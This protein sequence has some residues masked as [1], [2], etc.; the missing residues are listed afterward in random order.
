MKMHKLLKAFVKDK[1]GKVVIWQ[2]P[3]FPIVAWAVFTLAG[4]IAQG[5]LHDIFLACGSISLLI[6]ACLEIISGASYFR[7]TLG[8]VVLVATV[9]SSYSSWLA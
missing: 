6:W 5:P 8:L 4:R 3:N 7:R 2:V 9:Y 1:H